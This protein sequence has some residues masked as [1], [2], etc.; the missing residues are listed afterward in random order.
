MT[1]SSIIITAEVCQSWT[2]VAVIVFSIANL[3]WSL[4]SLTN[5]K[6]FLLGTIAKTNWTERLRGRQQTLSKRKQKQKQTEKQKQKQKQKC[7]SVLQHYFENNHKGSLTV[8][9]NGKLKA[10]IQWKLVCTPHGRLE[11]RYATDQ[12]T[13]HIWKH[14]LKEGKSCKSVSMISDA[15]KKEFRTN[16]A[17]HSGNQ[18]TNTNQQMTELT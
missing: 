16:T 11:S 12:F 15:H 5:Q 13:L 6:F 7:L 2:S 9:A 18:I 17:C 8:E 14:W 4:L 1:F 3:C 10:I